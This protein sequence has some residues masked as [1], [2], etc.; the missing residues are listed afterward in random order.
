MFIKYKME[1]NQI[2]IIWRFYSQMQM[3]HGKKLKDFWEED[4]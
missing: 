4:S 1:L 2:K 3:Q